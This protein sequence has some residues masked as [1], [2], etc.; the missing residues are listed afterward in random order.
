MAIVGTGR[1]VVNDMIR[2]RILEAVARENGTLRCLDGDCEQTARFYIQ[3]CAPVL[4]Q[5]TGA[6]V[7][8]KGEELN[9]R[10]Q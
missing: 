3:K 10:K 2:E 7:E 1:T 6:A 9:A 4:E 8:V 5:S